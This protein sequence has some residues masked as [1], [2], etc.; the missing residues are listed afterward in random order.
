MK[1]VALIL[2]LSLCGTGRAVDNRLLR[3]EALVQEDGSIKFSVIHGQGQT[4]A[5]AAVTTAPTAAATGAPTTAPAAIALT[6]AAATT[7]APAAAGTATTAIPLASKVKAQ[8]VVQMTKMSDEKTKDDG[9]HEGEE[10]DGDEDAGDEETEGEASK[11]EVKA[12]VHKA[13]G[14]HTW[15]LA[16]GGVLLAAG[17]I[18]VYVWF[19][20]PEQ[21]LKESQDKPRTSTSSTRSNAE[22][23]PAKGARRSVRER[24]SSDE[25]RS[26]RSRTDTHSKSNPRGGSLGKNGGK[27]ED[28][29]SKSRKTSK[30]SN[31]ATTEVPTAA[32]QA[33]GYKARKPPKDAKNPT[34]LAPDGTG[35]GNGGS[36]IVEPAAKPGGYKN[37]KQQTPKGSEV[38]QSV[39]TPAASENVG[40][41]TSTA[42]ATTVEAPPADTSARPS[43]YRRKQ[44]PSA[45]AA[46]KQAEGTPP[47]ADGSTAPAATNAPNTAD[48][49]PVEPA[50]VDTSARP[51]A[52][53]RKQHPSAAAVD[54]PAEGTAPAAASEDVGTAP[55]TTSAPNTV[56]AAQQNHPAAEAA[57]VDKPAEGTPPAA[58]ASE[59]VG[60]APA[61]TSAPS[62]A[63]ATAAEAP[64]VD[65]SARP[66]AYRS[67]KQNQSAEAVDK[68]AEGTPPAAAASEDVGTVPAATSAPSTAEATAAEA[69]AV[70]TSARPSAY[71]NRKQNQSPSSPV[72]N[73]ESG[74]DQSPAP[75]RRS[76]YR[77]RRQSAAAAKPETRPSAYRSRK[78]N[79][80]EEASKDEAKVIVAP[81]T[82]VLGD[83]PPKSWANLPG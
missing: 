74:G 4:P 17:A 47:A 46:D 67:R 5:D 27:E 37:R 9:N 51:S 45:A 29:K 34:D 80:T 78:Q 2:A 83:A 68:P 16:T 32:A 20:R 11:D 75:E 38:N 81:P 72:S 59:D 82:A 21:K 19:R 12:E 23:D 64:A 33:G 30:G 1:S 63:A 79:Q 70:D 43:A 40:A 24:S 65:T 69:P 71:R 7:A 56:E 52:Y 48:V 25:R 73:P 3:R 10:A 62:T 6:A 53:R 44:N 58:V 22:G 28:S 57:A 26:R 18:G 8:K 41:A 55:A 14:V 36:K 66:S 35:D 77:Q 60:T 54:K 49:T 42:D 76:S 50:P 39:A 13:S 31:D 61:A 15:S